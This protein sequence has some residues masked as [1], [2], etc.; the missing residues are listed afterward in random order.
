MPLKDRAARIA[1]SRR[2]YRNNREELKRM[3]RDRYMENREAIRLRRLELS[4]R[5]KAKNNER[6]KTRYAGL[7]ATVIEA[8]GS[9]CACCGEK[10][11]KFL[12][13]DHILNDGC[14]HRKTLGRGARPIYFF[15]KR[16]GFPK[17]AYQLL[18]ANCNQGKVRNGG[19]CPHQR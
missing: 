19:I 8:Y 17:D 16:N 5:H 2:R 18:C 15:L 7:R 10:E 4:D 1:Y 12:E 3:E 6:E 14:H 11:P 13:L 9:V